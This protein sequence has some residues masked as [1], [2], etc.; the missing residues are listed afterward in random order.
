VGVALCD[1]HERLLGGQIALE[2]VAR[3]SRRKIHVSPFQ[4]DIQAMR[5]E[6]RT[7]NDERRT[8]RVR[9][10]GAVLHPDDALT[11]RGSLLSPDGRIIAPYDLEQ[12]ERHMDG[13]AA[14]ASHAGILNAAVRPFELAYAKVS[15]VHVINGMGVTLGDSIIGLTALHA[16]KRAHPQVRFVL[17]R[18]AR[19]PRYV[20][21]LYALADGFI[22]DCRSLPWSLAQLPDDET[23]IDVGNHLFWPGFASLPMIDFFLSALGTDPACV[24]GRDKANRWLAA[25]HLPPL[26][27]EWRDR[28]Y[29]LFCPTSSTP[30]RSVPG[31]MHAALVERL[32]ERFD[33]PVL[34][35]GPVDHPG[36]VD[37]RAHSPDTAHFLAW[38]RHAQYVVASDTA[39]VHIAAGFDVPTTAFFTTIAPA[40]RVRDYPVCEPIA[41]DVPA[42]RDIQASSR[43]PD[44]AVIEAAFRRCWSGFAGFGQLRREQRVRLAGQSLRVKGALP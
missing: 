37:V 15:T 19:A 24:P 9:E 31:S 40:L 10:E 4:I 5:F 20:E 39:A 44:L 27:S 16:I 41:L 30:V 1:G 26:P 22:A 29:L 38:I 23:R 25:L 34:G 7:T 14:L 32:I 42:L 13:C 21:D 35:F 17:Y 28:P 12:E 36:Y 18:P 6:R 43:A 3:A 33:L 8:T 2:R 11:H